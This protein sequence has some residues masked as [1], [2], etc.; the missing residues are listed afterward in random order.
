MD[1]EQEFKVKKSRIQND[2]M[3]V[4]LV[5][6]NDSDFTSNN[7]TLKFILYKNHM[8]VLT[9][10][11]NCFIFLNRVEKIDPGIL[12]RNRKKLKTHVIGGAK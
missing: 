8:G 2:L 9:K 12:K 4:K 5:I 3:E 1:T 10:C 7:I 11:E 6:R